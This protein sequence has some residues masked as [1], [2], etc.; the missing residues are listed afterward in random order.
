LSLQH[1]LQLPTANQERILQAAL[2]EFLANGYDLASTNQIVE[3]AGI[4]KGVLFKYFADKE[5]LFLYL[6]QRSA[7]V[8]AAG[9]DAVLPQLSADFWEALKELTWHELALREGHPGDYALMEMVGASP[10]HPVYRKALSLFQTQGAAVY[11]HLMSTVSR[12]GLRQDLPFA[13]VMNLISWMGE[14][15]KQQYK[16]RPVERAAVMADL[17][18]YLNLLKTGLQG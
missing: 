6:C 13:Q 12:S 11:A 18:T 1:F 10:Q 4:S 14:G 8:V 3:R 16:V 7:E 5:S 17:A 2:A 15:L 9:Y